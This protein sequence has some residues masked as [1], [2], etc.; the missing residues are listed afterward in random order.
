MFI[1]DAET[2]KLLRE[3]VEGE[4]SDV[5]LQHLQ[6][7]VSTHRHELLPALVTS[8]CPEEC[9]WFVSQLCKTSSATALI[10]PSSLNLIKRMY[11]PNVTLTADDEINLARESPFVFRVYSEGSHNI[12][13]VKDCVMALSDHAQLLHAQIPH[14][15]TNAAL[16]SPHEFF[17][18]LPA[19]RDRGCYALDKKPGS[20][21]CTKN[22]SSHN[23][24]LPGIFTLHCP[25]SE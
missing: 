10:S 16:V 13:W 9:C 22:T 14:A 5:I 8:A 2:R 23:T 7:L 6:Q 17:P 15:T 21:L 20:S 19:V 11:Q 24:L 3:W 4:L 12:D 1:S 18:Y 25:H